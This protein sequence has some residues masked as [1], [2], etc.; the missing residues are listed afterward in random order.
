YAALEHPDEP[1][2][3]N[4]ETLYSAT[5]AVCHGP[6]AQGIEALGSPKLTDLQDWYMERQL[7]YFR[8]GL[9]GADPAD[10]LGLQMAVFSKTLTDDQAIADVVAYIKS[11]QGSAR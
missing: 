8:D 6:A 4:G 9:R 3:G 11:L 7:Q 2:I 5:C 1:D 10:T